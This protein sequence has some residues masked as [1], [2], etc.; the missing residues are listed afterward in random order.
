MFGHIIPIYFDYHVVPK[1][2]SGVF[3]YATS[4]WLALPYDNCLVQ[5]PFPDV[6]VIAAGAVV[7]TSTFMV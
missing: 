6:S 1:H 3:Q 7:H 2:K 4:A 5:M